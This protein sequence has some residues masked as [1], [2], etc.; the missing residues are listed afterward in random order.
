MDDDRVAFLR[1]E[2]EPETV[3]YHVSL[4]GVGV[5]ESVAHPHEH[6]P[7]GLTPVRAWQHVLLQ[8]HMQESLVDGLV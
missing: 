1:I 5:L 7:R 4:E 2:S 8:K 6:V 3:C